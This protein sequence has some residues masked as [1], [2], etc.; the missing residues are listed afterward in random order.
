MIVEGYAPAPRPG[1]DRPTAFEVAD[2]SQSANFVSRASSIVGWTHL[3]KRQMM[4]KIVNFQ[5]SLWV[6]NSGKTKLRRPVAS[7][8]MDGMP[9]DDLVIVRLLTVPLG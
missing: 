2:L 8:L 7:R 5:C 3:R 1:A 4:Q 6:P 9:L